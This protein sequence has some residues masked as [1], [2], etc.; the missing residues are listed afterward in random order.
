MIEAKSGETIIVP[1]AIRTVTLKRTETFDGVIRLKQS[2]EIGDEY[3]IDVASQHMRR[4]EL[5]NGTTVEKMCV[6]CIDE[7]GKPKG[8]IPSELFYMNSESLI[9]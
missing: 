7:N 6:T 2:S 3:R 8:W 1:R 4:F 9:V 5:T